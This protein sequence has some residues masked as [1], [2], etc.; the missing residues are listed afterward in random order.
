MNTL[1]DWDDSLWLNPPGIFRAAPF[2]SWNSRLAPQRL[3]RQ[4]QS[5]H[6]AGM[7]GFFMH[8]RY[9][10]KTPYLSEEWFADVTACLEAARTLH[11]K[12]CLYDEDRWPSGAA[13]GLVTREHPELALHKLVVFK[14]DSAAAESERIGS[15]AITF[16][17]AGQVRSYRPLEEGKGLSAGEKP[18]GFAVAIGSTSPWFNEGRYLDCMNPQAVAQFLRI[19]YQAYADRYSRDFG[20]LMPA[21]FT[22][23][24]NYAHAVIPHGDALFKLPW[25]P[26]L[27]M[28]FRRRRGY[29][30]RERLPELAWARC[31]RPGLPGPARTNSSRSTRTGRTNIS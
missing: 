15:F 23:E 27:P 14:S 17:S 19:T 16:D 4:I 10:L 28:E 29:D 12:A 21:I 3:A 26:S 2:W 30:L 13:G 25:T 6:D 1:M 24:P 18:A 9:G 11:M 8:S 20:D 22:D 5:M 7:G 31:T